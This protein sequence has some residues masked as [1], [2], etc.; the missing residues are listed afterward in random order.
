[1][2]FKFQMQITSVF[3]AATFSVCALAAGG[4]KSN[5]SVDAVTQLGGAASGGENTISSL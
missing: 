5:I 4:S 1:M 2:N 3:I